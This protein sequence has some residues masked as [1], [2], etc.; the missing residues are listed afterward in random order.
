ME[1]LVMRKR[2]TV[3]LIKDTL[4]SP[5]RTR[6]PKFWTA[7]VTITGGVPAAGIYSFDSSGE[8]HEELID[9]INALAQ[10]KDIDL[11]IFSAWRR[12]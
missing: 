11:G 4:C 5:R 10:E 3:L 9:Q 2:C 7:R 6:Y 12:W 8:L 1:F